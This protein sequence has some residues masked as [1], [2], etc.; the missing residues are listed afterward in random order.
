[1]RAK[2]PSVTTSMRVLRL[3]FEPSRTRKPTVSPTASPSV[4]AMRLGRGASGETAGLEQDELASVDPGLVEKRER[5]TRGLACARRRDQDRVRSA[6][7][8]PPSARQ[9]SIDG[10]RCLESAHVA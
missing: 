6:R 5:N 4:C 3:I 9:N 8:G 2:T 1:M 7:A 10:Q